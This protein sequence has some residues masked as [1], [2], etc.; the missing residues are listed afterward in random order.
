MKLPSAEEYC[1]QFS[2]KFGT[3]HVCENCDAMR[4]YGNALLEA[5]AIAVSEDPMSDTGHSAIAVAKI[6]ALKEDR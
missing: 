6:R 3:S 2:R 5:A 1:L 4:V